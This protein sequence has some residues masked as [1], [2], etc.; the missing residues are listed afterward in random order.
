MSEQ[1]RNT[2]ELEVTNFGPVV[3]AKIDLRPLTVFVGPSNT[4]KSYLAILIYALHRVFGGNPRFGRRRFPGAFPYPTNTGSQELS[5]DSVDSL[6]E[7]ADSI[8]SGPKASDQHN[9]V[10]PRPAADA[11]RLGLDELV[12]A[13]SGEIA[14]CFGVG[15]SYSLI[16]RS[17]RNSSC[18]VMR[19]QVS[20]VGDP[21][22]HTFELT[23]NPQF[24][25]MVPAEV[26]IPVDF[27]SVDGMSLFL[28]RQIRYLNEEKLDEPRRQF[29]AMELLPS[30]GRM[31]LPSLVSPLH[32]PAYYLP[33]D[34][35]GV[36]H[37]HSVV[38]SAL[39]ANAPTA[40]LRPAARTPML[41]G[42]LADFLEQ[43]IEIDQTGRGRRKTE[44][45][46][47]RNIEE[48]ILGGSVHI[49]RSAHVD[50]P[51]FAYQPHGWK[52]NLALANASSMVSE[53]APVVLYL[54]H[55][56]E[57]GNVLIV[58]EPE[59]HLHPAMQVEFTRQLAVLVEAGIRVIVTTHSE[60][61]LEELANIVRRSELSRAERGDRISLR[62]DQVGAWLFESKQRP[63][64]SVVQEISLDGSGLY[65]SGY[66]EVARALHN[67]WA[68]IS[69]R[70]EN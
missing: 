3:E 36:M 70:I 50:Y 40:G 37:A 69:S 63:K 13:L 39:I 31:M 64:G 54:R 68:D 10:L 12:G 8:A 29:T 11:L 41:S 56:V 62:P 25:T 55:M 5:K 22:Q 46:I 61:L 67:E 27:K 53:L 20:D 24:K 26:G 19:R 17:S 16:R 18:V 30:L 23:R 60:W 59:S 44:G 42:V 65:P 21:A 66:D 38:V 47:G 28:H 32:L 33:A 57:P 43:L 34:R 45:D 58:E 14:R 4:G 6:I 15:E 2:L 1:A 48:M 52:A 9:L 49:D 51:R 35:T 7:M